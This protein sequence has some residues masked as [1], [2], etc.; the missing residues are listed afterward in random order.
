[1]MSYFRT[2]IEPKPKP[3]ESPEIDVSFDID[4]AIQKVGKPNR[5]EKWRDREAIVAREM[6][7]Q[8]FSQSQIGKYLGY[9]RSTVKRRLNRR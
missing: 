4:D 6:Q 2:K 1:M 5:S 7:K 9:S 3:K 8:G